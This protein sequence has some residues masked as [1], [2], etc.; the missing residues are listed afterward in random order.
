VKDEVRWG[1]ART[2]R[3][4]NWNVSRAEIPGI[5]G[6]GMRTMNHAAAAAVQA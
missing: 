4:N 5:G 2:W 1:T 6:W 3:G